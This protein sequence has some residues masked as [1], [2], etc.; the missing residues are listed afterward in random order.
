M[1][2]DKNWINKVLIWFWNFY[3]DL[4]SDECWVCL[5]M[6]GVDWVEDLIIC[7]LGWW[8]LVV[9]VLVWGCWLLNGRE[10]GGML[11]F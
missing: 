11:V 9:L 3:W 1:I 2:F 6:Y 10:W 7:G 5:S 4:L 8:C